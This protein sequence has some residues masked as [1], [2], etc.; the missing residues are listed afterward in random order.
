MLIWNENYL[1]IAKQLRE[2]E[3]QFI[4]TK[5]EEIE[6]TYRRRAA[7]AT[8]TEL[9][10][11][12]SSIVRHFHDNEFDY[13]FT[14]KRSIKDRVQDWVVKLSANSISNRLLTAIFI[15]IN[16][17][18]I[19]LQRTL[20]AATLSIANNK[21]FLPSSSAMTAAASRKRSKSLAVK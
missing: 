3:L 15:N 11:L 20:P 1:L 12:D 8:L 16:K 19:Y 6:E 13:P 7:E 5:I 10:M 4:Q 14:R 21:F 2:F 18:Q 17:S 9:K